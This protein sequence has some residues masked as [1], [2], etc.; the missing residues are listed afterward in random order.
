MGKRNHKEDKQKDD[1]KNH[2]YRSVSGGVGVCPGWMHVWCS[3]H[4][5]ESAS[6]LTE[7]SL[8]GVDPGK[9]TVCPP[10]KTLAERSTA[11]A[12]EIVGRFVEPPT[13]RASGLHASPRKPRI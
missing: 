6:H 2:A 10:G 5:W 11:P 12:A 4:R 13:L 1:D 8:R 3:R 7:A 9:S